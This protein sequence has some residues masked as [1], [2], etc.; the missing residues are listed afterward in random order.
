MSNKDRLCKRSMT[1]SVVRESAQGD[2]E[3]DVSSKKEEQQH[4]GQLR[5][6]QEASTYRWRAFEL[7]CFCEIVDWTRLEHRRDHLG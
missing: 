1:E 3:S 5:A 6:K 2:E 7:V 4:R